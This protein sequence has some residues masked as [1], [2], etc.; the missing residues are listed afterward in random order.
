LDRALVEVHNLHLAQTYVAP[1]STGT[2]VKV[3]GGANA[4]A[5]NPL[6]GKVSVFAGA[7]SDNYLN[8]EVTNGGRLA[9]GEVWY[10]GHGSSSSTFAHVANNSTFTLTGSRLAVPQTGYSIRIDDLT[11]RATVLTS[12]PDAPVGVFGSGNGT[13][14]VNGNESHGS[15]SYFSMSA[16]ATLGVFTNNRWYDPA[17]GSHSVANQGNAD[18]N[19]AQA[20]LAHLRSE[21]PLGDPNVLPTGVTDLRLYRVAID[22][23]ITGLRLQ[24]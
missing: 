14:W 3:V 23:A 5:G 20:M 15:G 4:S 19:L 13:V 2:G 17:T 8:F 21:R 11:G 12:Q 9:V 16:P 10:E 22:S 6:G 1:A 18:N 7:S 24:P